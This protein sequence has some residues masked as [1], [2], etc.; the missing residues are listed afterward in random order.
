[1]RGSQITL[2]HSQNCEIHT[3]MVDKHSTHASNYIGLSTG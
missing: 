2:V 3:Y 1:M